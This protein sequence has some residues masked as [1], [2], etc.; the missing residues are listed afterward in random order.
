[1]FGLLFDLIMLLRQHRKLFSEK[2]LNEKF[3][4]VE[5]QHTTMTRNSNKHMAIHVI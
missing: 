5:G 4:E 1:M 2:K 3:T